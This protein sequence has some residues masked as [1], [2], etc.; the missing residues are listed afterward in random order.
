MR[1]ADEL[2]VRVRRSAKR[3]KTVSWR[4]TG[5]ILEI[6]IPARLSVKEEKTWVAKIRERVIARRAISQPSGDAALLAHAKR[7]MVKY[8]GQPLPLVEIVWTKRQ[9]CLYGSCTPGTGAIRLAERLRQVPAWVRD[10]VIVH[11]LAHLL[12]ADHSPA[13]WQLVNRYPL[14]ER[15]RG[16]LLAMDLGLVA[17]GDEDL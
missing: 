1:E 17:K 2:T 11:E 5:N 3:K 8:F 13:F 12:H 6:A 9:K 14:A 7:L 4:V 16:F 15:A 10:Y